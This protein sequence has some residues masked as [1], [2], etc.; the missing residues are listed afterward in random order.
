VRLLKVF[1]QRLAEEEL[2]V[3]VVILSSLVL[4]AVQEFPKGVALSWYIWTLASGCLSGLI[5]FHNDDTPIPVDF[6]HVFQIFP[7]GQGRPVLRSVRDNHWEISSK[8]ILVELFGGHFF[9]GT[10]GH[11]VSKLHGIP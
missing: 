3:D 9:Q 5:N 11:F 10:H 1:N 4:S 7:F 8:V 6:C 2:I